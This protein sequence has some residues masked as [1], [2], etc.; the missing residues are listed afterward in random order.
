MPPPKE[1]SSAAMGGTGQVVVLVLVRWYWPGGG[2]GHVVVLVMWWS[3]VGQVVVVRS[4][5]SGHGG[6]V[7]V[8][9]RWLSDDA[10]VRWCRGQAVVVSRRWSGGGTGQARW[11]SA[12][13]PSLSRTSI[14]LL[15]ECRE[16]QHLIYFTALHIKSY[17]YI[18]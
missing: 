4:W 12:I 1:G 16:K 18:Y 5:W 14:E 8:L 3:G 9:F 15:I 6:Q 11:W 10:V 7:V 13:P 17:I 2:T